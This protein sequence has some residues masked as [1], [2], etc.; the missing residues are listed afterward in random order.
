MTFAKHNQRN[1]DAL[2]SAFKHFVRDSSFP[3][4]GAKSALAQDQIEVVIARD[5]RSNW[6]DL[7][8]IDKLIGFAKSYENSPTLFRSF[9]V[10]FREPDNLFESQFEQ[11]L[12]ERVQSLSDKDSLFGMQ[13]D[14]RASADPSDRRFSLSFGGEAFFVV[15]LHPKASRP[16]RRFI[17]PA[18]VF[19]LHNQ[20]EQLRQEGRYETLRRAILDRDLVLAGSPNPMLSRYGES[21]EARQYSGRA[22]DSDWRCPYERRDF[23]WMQTDE[24]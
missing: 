24:S 18:L 19:N 10:I 7:R 23:T 13:T 15:G 2:I 12:W 9:V 20:F 4:V 11:H 16:A 14:A 5:I 17:K 1:E 6:D 8:V 3:C 22:V 21:S